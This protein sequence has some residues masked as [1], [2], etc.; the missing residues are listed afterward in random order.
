VNTLSSRWTTLAKWSTPLVWIALTI[1]LLVGGYRETEEKLGFGYYSLVV[2][3]GVFG[4]LTWWF[5]VWDLA[6]E[7]VDCGDALLVRR[8]EIEEKVPLTNIL[9]VS[10][11]PFSESVR[12]VVQ[13]IVPGQFGRVI[14]FMPQKQPARINPFAKNPVVQDLAA[15]VLSARDSAR[16]ASSART[17]GLHPG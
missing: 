12:I 14:A 2:A 5:M 9:R 13:L 3:F 15:R 7:V 6:D 4:L 11:S 1:F 17:S 10:E 8:G 16:R